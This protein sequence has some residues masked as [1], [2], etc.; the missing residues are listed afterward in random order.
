MAAEGVQGRWTI[1]PIKRGTMLI[2]APDS[3]EQVPVVPCDAAAVERG[4]RALIAS[5][6]WA[7]LAAAASE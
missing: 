6:S 3:T 1:I 2:G 7:V 4:A 5:F